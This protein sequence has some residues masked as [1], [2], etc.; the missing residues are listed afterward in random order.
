M[1]LD[2]NKYYIE[3]AP[4]NKK[5]LVSHPKGKEKEY[6]KTVNKI[7]KKERIDFVHAQPDPEVRIISDHRGEIKAKT[8]LPSQK[9]V[10]ISQDKWKTY[11]TLEKAQVPVAFTIKL[12]EEA[13]LKEAFQ[14]IDGAIWLRA[15]SGHGGKASLP[16]TSFDQAKM[17]VSYWLGK[18][19]KWSDFLASET[20]TGTE[21]SWLSVWKDGLL[22][23]SQG[24]ERVEWVEAGLSPS[25]VTGTTAI[26]RTVSSS[27]VNEVGTKTVLALDKK[28]EGIYVVDTK[29][30]RLGV[31]CVM[32]INPGRFFTTSL[33]FAAAGVNM[34]YIY[35]QLAYGE[36]PKKVAPYNSVK[37]DIY[38]MRI[39]DGGP[40]MIK[41]NKWTS[42][43]I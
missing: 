34:P 20:L 15:S 17:W 23:C 33:F 37:E 10:E 36:T 28:P 39:P 40:V 5:Y 41:N 7:I 24:K 29:E 43:K 6:I 38:W 25:G 1:G 32:E 19:L 31:P 30:N 18:G 3:M 9:A 35:T 26:Q 13:T 12:K 27:K 14:K 16:V 21:V 2:V 22:V 42:I 4:V 8:L 11:Q